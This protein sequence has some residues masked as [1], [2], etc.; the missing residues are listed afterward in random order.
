[1][2]EWRKEEINIL[3]KSSQ[4]HDIIAANCSLNTSPAQTERDLDIS[5]RQFLFG[6]GRKGALHSQLLRIVL[7][8]P[9]PSRPGPHLFYSA[10]GRLKLAVRRSQKALTLEMP[11]HCPDSKRLESP[12]AN[13]LLIDRSDTVLD[14]AYACVLPL[15]SEDAEPAPESCLAFQTLAKAKITARDRFPCQQARMFLTGGFH[16]ASGPVPRVLLDPDCSWHFPGIGI[17]IP[18]VPPT[19]ATWSRPSKTTPVS[20][21]AFLNSLQLE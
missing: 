11:T 2:K 5:I 1:M 17:A 20:C 6:G 14:W 21:P 10:W 13:G 12:W 3:Y 19:W 15:S 16:W 4:F 18:R 7:M 9:E 8:S